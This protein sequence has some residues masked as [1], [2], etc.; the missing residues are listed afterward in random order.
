LGTIC[1][2]GDPIRR[3]TNTRALR[4]AMAAIIRIPSAI[5]AR[6]EAITAADG[7]AQLL[8]CLGSFFFGEKRVDRYEQ[9]P[10]DRHQKRTEGQSNNRIEQGGYEPGDR[11]R[12]IVVRH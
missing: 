9:G 3:L 5:I 12:H 7:H 8:R 1:L 4:A 2:F 10:N 6:K 11:T